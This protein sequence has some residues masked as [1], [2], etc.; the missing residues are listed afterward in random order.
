MTV[1]LY[2][3]DPYQRAF[4]AKVMARGELQ[5]RPTVVLD[6]TAFYATSG[7]QPND[8]GVLDGVPVID[9]LEVDGDVV[10]VLAGPLTGDVVHGEIDWERR[11]DHMQQHTGQHILSQALVQ[12][13][14][15]ETVSFHLS[16]DSV[17]VDVNLPLLSPE[18]IAAA[19]RLANEAVWAAQPVVVSEHPAE[20]MGML[21]LRKQPDVEGTLRVV[22]VAAFDRCACGGTHVRNSGEVGLIHIA[23]CEPQRGNTRI[24]FMCG[25]RALR[26]YGARDA[27]LR[28]LARDLGVG[29]S[30]LPERI[31]RL[32]EQ[33][34][35]AR[36]MVEALRMRLLD[37]ELPRLAASAEQRS[38]Y[39]LL[40]CVLEGLDAGNMRYIAQQLLQH[41]GMVVLLGVTEPSVQFCF[42]RSAD[43]DID[44][45]RLLRQAGEPFK[46]RGGGKPHLAQGGGIGPAELEPLLRRAADILAAS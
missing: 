5:G 46:A 19:E 36:K 11:F 1:K 14:G 20:Q 27:L 42:G 18:Q 16:A 30:E 34:E 4:D 43:L 28:S 29:W 41:P 40:A 2:W 8:T 13:A 45:N 7:G 38:G 44:M 25:R 24:E 22:A 37:S 35:T 10:H 32:A 21:G 3:R 12:V 39:R 15:A 33:G 17:T 9:V 26:D 31:A 6:Q 23:R